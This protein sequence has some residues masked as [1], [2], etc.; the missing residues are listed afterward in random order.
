MYTRLLKT[1]NRTSYFLFGPRGTGK[2]SWIKNYYQDDHVYIDLLDDETF[3]S[4][5]A[6]PAKLMDW[7][8][9]KR[10]N[11]P[12]VIDEVQKI[13]S[14]MDE[15]HR[16]IEKEKLLFVLT[17]S[18]ARKLRRGGANLLAGRAQT[19]EMFPLTRQ[20]IG[21]DFNLKRSLQCGHLPLAVTSE[22][23]KAFLNSYI[24]TY[25][26]EEIQAEGLTRSLPNFARFLQIASY[27]QASPLVI[28]NV[29]QEIGIERK[30]VEDYFSILR[31]LLL[32]IE[33]PIFT[34]RKKQELITKQKFFYFEAG[35]FQTLRPRGVLDSVEEIN[36]PALETL[37][38][39]EMK[40]INSYSGIDYEISYWH[41]RAHLE[42][43]F[44][45]YGPKGFIA[46]EV[47]ASQ[48]LRPGH[49]E[50]LKEFRKDYPEAETIMVYLGNERKQQ[51]GI[52]IIPAEEFLTDLAAILK[53]GKA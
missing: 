51:E 48:R 4:L 20:E 42:V 14:L 19:L 33:L 25:L 44:V 31:D 12:I 8:P 16:L 37:I 53:S 18:S 38:I 17:V 32:S 21:S 5:L 35:V 1:P 15:I 2:T 43:D 36:G 27:S 23:P 9:P 50:G 6:Q 7:I 3:R 46:I 28:S 49:F 29:A 41:T 24:N 11:L 40:A 30:V 22:K 34:K 45:L 26:K 10:R 52:H 13:S 47:K 39:Q